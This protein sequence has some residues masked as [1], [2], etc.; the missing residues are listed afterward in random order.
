MATGSRSLTLKLIADI[1]DFNKNLNKG[2]N[3]VEGFGG[4]IEKFGKMAGAAFVAAGVAAA[5]YAGKLAIDGVKAAIEDEAAQVRLAGAL[6]AATGATNEQIKAVEDQILKTSLATG[7][8]D[9]ELR[10]AMQRLAVSLGSTSK[11]QETL[12]LALDVSKATGKPLEAVA[13]ALAKANDGNTTSLAKL[14]VGLTAAELKSMSFKDAQQKLTDLWGGAASEH[15]KTFQGRIERLKVG[16]DEAKEAVGTAL[17]PIIEKLIQYVMD[18]AIPFISKMKDSFDKV[19]DAIVNNQDKFKSFFEV[20]KW[21][22]PIIGTILGGAFKVVAEIASNVISIIA[23]VLGAIKPMLN[24]AISGI[25]AV[26]SGLNLINPFA[27][28]PPIPSVGGAGSTPTIP[29]LNVPSM[30]AGA[31]AGGGTA[32]GGSGGSSG[33]GSSGSSWTPA[34][35]GTAGGGAMMADQRASINIT[36]NGAIDPIGTAQTIYDTISN[37][38]TTSG[39][40][41]N[42]GGSRAIL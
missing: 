6:K 4:K 35:A 1:D 15:A 10:P 9:D 37:A 34:Y 32:G 30:G 42:F 19:R 18:Y 33:S 11:A 16:F 26:I 20:I 13:N 12:N 40:F 24:F 41:T 39:Q 25:N 23:Q 36:V 5:A 22:A 27:D 7:V 17:L 14:G 21:A 28:I 8:A 29:S 31:S 3:E 2:S 38:A